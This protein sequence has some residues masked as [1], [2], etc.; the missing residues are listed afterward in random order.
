MTAATILD[1]APIAL[2]P[3]AIMIRSRGR[4]I[5]EHGR[6]IETRGG[7]QRDL[8]HDVGDARDDGKE[9]QGPE[10][11]GLPAE[12]RA[13][14]SV[15]DNATLVRNRRL[16]AADEIERTR[17]FSTQDA[18]PLRIRSMGFP[19]GAALALKMRPTTMPSQST[20]KSSSFHWRHHNLA[21]DNAG[22]IDAAFLG[23]GILS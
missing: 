6:P 12:L 19:T 5:L 13:P 14:C 15:A 10:E 7:D 3:G 11:L 22:L 8:G 4:A 23:P 18:R 9:S 1:V 17:G 20:S 16:V 21:A 2:A